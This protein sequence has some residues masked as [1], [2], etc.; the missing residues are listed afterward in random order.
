MKR[1]AVVFLALLFGMACF[2][3]LRGN[4]SMQD[5]DAIAAP[6]SR[7]H[8]AG[9]DELGRD[10]ASRTGAAVIFGL[11]SAVL[12]AAVCTGLAL[13]VGV[14]AAF[15]PRTAGSALLYG[16]DL[17]L[18]LP[19]LY[20]LMVVR[21]SLPL[22][23]GAYPGAAI[24]FGLL[25]LLGWPVYVRSLYQRSLSLRG[26]GWL[27]QAR[28]CGLSGFRLA[29]I[30]LLPHL[31]PLYLTQFLLCVPAFIVAEANLGALGM[32]VAAPLVSWGS[33]LQ[34]LA[35]SSQLT[36]GRWVYLPLAMLVAVLFSLELLIPE[37][38]R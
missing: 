16:S 13:I 19:W 15:A 33:L 21:S 12:A 22:T 35:S 26:Q 31:R 2:T 4:S 34:E 36:A 11:A 28:A 10:R 38:S 7:T 25:A 20:L 23:L 9:T 14:G 1:S 5:R 27:L 24:T 18:M 30:H 17:F 8:P 6:S 3:V 29:R 32:G 37:D